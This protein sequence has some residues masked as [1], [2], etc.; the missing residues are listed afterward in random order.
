MRDIS[1][2]P[3]RIVVHGELSIRRAGDR[4]DSL[5]TDSAVAGLGVAGLGVAGVAAGGVDDVVSGGLPRAV[6]DREP[7]RQTLDRK[8]RSARWVSRS[9]ILRLGV[10]DGDAGE[11]DD[12]F[13]LV[14]ALKDV[15]GFAFR[16]S[17]AMKTGTG[18]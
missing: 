4:P 12:V 10:D 11:V 8:G 16:E 5:R 17:I 13:D 15:D 7:E 18:L 14:A 2:R 1:P 3:R 6:S 9:G